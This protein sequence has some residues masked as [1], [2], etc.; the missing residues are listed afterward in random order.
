MVLPKLLFLA[1]RGIGVEERPIVSH[2]EMASRQTSLGAGEG[3]PRLALLPSSFVAN[4]HGEQ[5]SAEGDEASRKALFETSSV[6]AAPFPQQ[7]PGF[8][9]SRSGVFSPCCE[10]K[11]ASSAVSS[12]PSHETPALAL[13]VRTQGLFSEGRAFT[14]EP[15]RA[16]AALATAKDTSP[17]EASVSDVPLVAGLNLSEGA[18]P[19]QRPHLSE[20]EENEEAVGRPVVSTEALE[21]FMDPVK[22]EAFLTKHGIRVRETPDAFADFS[23]RF[24]RGICTRLLC[25]PK[26]SAATERLPLEKAA[27]S[28]SGALCK[29][30]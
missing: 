29:S 15:G 17:V 21:D 28:C 22:L 24:L 6:F 9:S 25:S 30:S 26:N 20:F 2:R 13:P 18:P 23:V 5:S 8:F 11:A 10:R 14:S 12:L 3:D 19:F 1:R 4:A 27:A 7:P 16:D